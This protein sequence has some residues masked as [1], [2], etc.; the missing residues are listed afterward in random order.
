MKK[1]KLLFALLA[2]VFLTPMSKAAFWNWTHVYVRNNT[3]CEFVR[4]KTTIISQNYPRTS[5]IHKST[6]K[7]KIDIKPHSRQWIFSIPRRH[8]GAGVNFAILLGQGPVMVTNVITNLIQESSKKYQKPKAIV[9]S[10]IYLKSKPRIHIGVNLESRAR[11]SSAGQFSY[12]FYQS[13]AQF[14]PPLGKKFK[15]SYKWYGRFG[16]IYKNLFITIDPVDPNV[17][18]KKESK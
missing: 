10:S 1:K 3:N 9:R 15:V 18:K 13:K 2:T 7:D 8:S 11:K 14:P 17:C 5:I 4:G 6:S 12:I 16:Q